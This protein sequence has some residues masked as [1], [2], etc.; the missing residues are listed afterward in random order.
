MFIS[1]FSNYKKTIKKKY[2]E[3][4]LKKLK[5]YNK[6]ISFCNYLNKYLFKLNESVYNYEK[7]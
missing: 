3:L 5:E 2:K 6:L 1:F 7:Y 4:I